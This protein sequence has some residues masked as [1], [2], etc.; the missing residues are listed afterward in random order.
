MITTDQRAF[1]RI[2][3]WRSS[4]TSSP[5]TIISMNLYDR[6]DTKKGRFGEEIRALGRFDPRFEFRG[7]ARVRPV[8]LWDGSGWISE[9]PILARSF[10]GQLFQ[11]MAITSFCSGC[12]TALEENVCQ[13]V[14]AAPESHAY[15]QKCRISDDQLQILLSRPGS[16]P[17]LL[18]PRQL[19]PRG[20]I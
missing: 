18:P 5:K 13:P 7:V 20:A 9:T 16:A 14:G 8:R 3:F 4:P 10:L 2:A 19:S 1:D 6:S 17:Y 11:V 12:M 15:L